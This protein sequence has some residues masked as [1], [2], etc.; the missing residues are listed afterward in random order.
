MREEEVLGVERVL[1]LAKEEIGRQMDGAIEAKRMLKK[2]DTMHQFYDG[3][4]FG[5]Q[6]AYEVIFRIK[7]VHEAQRKTH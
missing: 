3:K 7:Q 1:Y 6:C 2:G 4:L 5:L